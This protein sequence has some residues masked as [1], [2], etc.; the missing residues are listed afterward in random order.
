MNDRTDTNRGPHSTSLVSLAVVALEAKRKNNFL[1]RLHEPANA[2][3]IVRRTDASAGE[4]NIV[5][6]TSKLC[7]DDTRKFQSSGDREHPS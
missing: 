5:T 4:T 7:E 1:G 2:N 3:V 6:Q